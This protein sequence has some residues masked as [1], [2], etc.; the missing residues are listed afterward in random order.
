M[1]LVLKIAVTAITIFYGLVPAIADLNETH[2]F[3]PLWSEH[4]RFHGAWFLAFAAGI[5]LVALFLTW[6]RDDVFLPIAFGLIFVAGF[7]VATIFGPAYGGALVDENGYVQTVL[8]LDS[9][10][11]LFSVVGVL[12]LI[13]LALAMRVSRTDQ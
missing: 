9:N 7:W 2:L 10:M 6:V 1:K 11:F 13:L 4:A 8:G 3:N 12:L 5:A